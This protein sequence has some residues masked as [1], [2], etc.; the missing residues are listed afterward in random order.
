MAQQTTN[1]K[2]PN[3]PAYGEIK[4]TPKVMLEVIE[5]NFPCHWHFLS[6]VVPLLTE[7]SNANWAPWESNPSFRKLNFYLLRQ[8]VIFRF[9]FQ[10]KYPISISY[11]FCTM[12]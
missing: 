10:I 11:K 6:D 5:V 3:C 4:Q 7:V 1:A 8:S 12:I 2:T 9:E